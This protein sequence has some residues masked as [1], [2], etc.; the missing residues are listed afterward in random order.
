MVALV[1]ASMKF[2]EGAWVIVVIIPIIVVTFLG[3]SRHY[4]HFEQ[5]RNF[6]LPVR[7]Q[8]IQH[9]LVVPIDQ[10][11]RAAI[12]SLAYARSIS[13][14]VTA[15]HVVVDEGQVERLQADWE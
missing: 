14:H 12:Q 2:A 3:I 7:P 8:D 10:L 13:P 11:D 15:V 5:K 9:R 6:N 4:K 1:I